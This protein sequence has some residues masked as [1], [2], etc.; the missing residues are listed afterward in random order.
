LV[1]RQHFL[2]SSSHRQTESENRKIHDKC[3]INKGRLHIKML[4][5]FSK[6]HS[7]NQQPLWYSVPKPARRRLAQ[8][9]RTRARELRRLGTLADIIACA[10]LLHEADAGWAVA[11]EIWGVDT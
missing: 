8:E 5:A 6:H 7:I 3:E 1:Q 11:S 10:V 9:L 2:F 4:G